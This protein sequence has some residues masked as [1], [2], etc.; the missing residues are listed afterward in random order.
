MK[1]DLRVTDS[2]GEE[3]LRGLSIEQQRD[4]LMDLEWAIL[5]L[6]GSVSGALPQ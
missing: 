6:E 1:V 2:A 3:A 4:W 5:C